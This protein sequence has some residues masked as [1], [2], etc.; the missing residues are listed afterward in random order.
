MQARAG[1]GCFVLVSA[2]SGGGKTALVQEFA[3]TLSGQVPVLWGACDPLATPRP[4]GPLYDVRDELGP[5]AREL[6]E[7]SGRAHDIYTSVF[8]RLRS[9]PCVLV[10]EDL[11]WSDQG[12]IE[13]LRFLLRRV[14]STHS[15]VV[16]TVRG[17]E[18]D[19]A[20]PQSAL[21]GDLAR[22]PDAVRLDLAPFSKEALQVLVGDRSLDADYLLSLTAGNPF[23]VNEMLDHPSNEL[24]PTVRDAILARTVDLG[25]AARDLIELLVC[26]PEAIPDR[27]LPMLGID[28]E[29]LRSLNRAG[30]I[31]RGLAGVAFRH[32]LC[33]QAVA[34]TIPPGAEVALHRRVLEALEAAGP[35]DPAVLVH[36]ARGA[37]DPKRVLTYAT[38]AAEAAARTGAHSQA[39]E[40]YS[41]ALGTGEPTDNSLRATLLER[42]A[43]E[44]YLIDRL[45]E[46]IKA[47]QMAIVLREQ[48][49]DM[50]NVSLDH[51]ALAVYQ[52][53]YADREAADQHASR[54]VEVLASHGESRALGLAFALQAYLA[55]QV[56]ALT[57]ASDLLDQA[58]AV[59]KRA[60]DP[61][62][63][64]RI[65]LVEAVRRVAAG[66]EGARDEILTMVRGAYPFDDNLSSGFSN[67]AYSDVEFRRL[68]DASEVLEQSLPLTVEWDL[69]ICHVWQMGARG[70]LNL[71]RGDWAA[72]VEDSETVLT[73]PSAPLARTW[74]SLIRGL[75]K[76]RSGQDAGPDLD[77]SWQL[78][79]RLG[80]PLRLLPAASAVLEQAWLLGT[81][82]P[83]VDAAVAMLHDISAP[84]LA[85]AR[86]DL[87]VWA[88]RLIPGIEVDGLDVATP[89]RLQLSGQPGD[90]AKAWEAVGARYEQALA[91][92]ESGGTKQIR[93]GLDLLDQ[94]GADAIAGKLRRDLRDTGEGNIPAKRRQ[95]TRS[96]G[97]GLTVREAEVLELLGEGLSNTELASRLFI[98]P[99][100]VDHHV[101]SILFKLGVANR[102]QAAQVGREL[103][104]LG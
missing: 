93:R 10:V 103:G 4:L 101:S 61:D 82:D 90:A 45:D 14:G 79:H 97:A 17:D 69:P 96:N 88:R 54:A 27:L 6:L 20:E 52:W 1:R 50:V 2:E 67:L 75:V 13:V 81:S 63:N 33:R 36:H 66:E 38:R 28:V 48:A 11:H 26:A 44:E 51:Q 72:A 92:V 30:L 77:D 74:P 9:D 34:T 32:D 55:I 57:Q 78:A 23:F 25:D 86:G 7:G 40:F 5:Q 18:V 37:Q 89:H 56:S 60:A 100:T 98:S 49:D 42:L 83:R 3:R 53:Y 73:M 21:F 104:I 8:Q 41:L 68:S 58:S 16:V 43:M 80:E 102:R 35:A 99:K 15:M 31:Q 76:L 19:P 84:G 22:S 47:C 87:A 71:L 85:W 24:P 59:A 95:S 64:A 39:A 12:T 65:D 70:R 91:L 62:L 94:L 46:A 29:A